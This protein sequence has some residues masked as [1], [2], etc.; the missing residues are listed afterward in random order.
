MDHGILSYTTLQVQSQNV[1]RPQSFK[2]QSL[3]KGKLKNSL[4]RIKIVHYY[5]MGWGGDKRLDTTM[6]ITIKLVWPFISN[7]GR[8]NGKKVY[9]W[10]PMSLWPQ[11]RPKNRWEN[12]IRNDTKKLKIKNWIGCIQD[13]NKWKSNVDTAKTFK[14]WSCSA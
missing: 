10:K 4:R 6:C 13:H 9:K 3:I 7:N 2:I 5:I 11:G 12:N 14:D 8:E 1:G